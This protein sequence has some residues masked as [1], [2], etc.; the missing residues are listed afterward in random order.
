M[1]INTTEIRVGMILEYKNSLKKNMNILP[2]INL[3][4]KYFDEMKKKYN[5]GTNIYY[6]LSGL[7][8]IHPTFI[9]RMLEAKFE[10]ED[11][12]STIKNL[13]LIGATSFKKELLLSLIH[14]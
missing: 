12:L 5:W 13:K 10:K 1:K 8:S 4:E 11:I 2:I 6:F 14:I 9:Q 3:K 7:H